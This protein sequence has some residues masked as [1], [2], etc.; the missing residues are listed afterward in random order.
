MQGAR[1][2]W[3]V[4]GYRA[5]GIL[6]SLLRIVI[7]RQ[8]DGVVPHSTSCNLAH[9]T[10]QRSVFYGPSVSALPLLRHHRHHEASRSAHTALAPG[11]CSALTPGRTRAGEGQPGPASTTQP[12]QSLASSLAAA[13]LFHPLSPP[14]GR[15]Q[16]CRCPPSRRLFRPTSSQ[17]RCATPRPHRGSELAPP[18]L[19]LF[20]SPVITSLLR[21]RS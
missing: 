10:T 9:I 13:P 1:D 6:G 21:L 12:G 19:L 18:I 11:S 17:P 4:C 8:N 2:L 14:R 16:P 15:G 3:A 7:P 5:V 20:L